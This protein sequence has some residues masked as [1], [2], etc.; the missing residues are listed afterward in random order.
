VTPDSIFWLMDSLRAGQSQVIE[1]QARLSVS[2]PFVPFPLVSASRVSAIN[3]TL[4]TNNSAGVTVYGIDRAA[5]P[6]KPIPTLVAEP[7]IVQVGE[8]IQLKAQVTASVSAWDLWVYYVNGEVDTTFAD[9][10][11]AAT[12]L[13]PNTWQ[14]IVPQFTN[15]R[16]LTAARI[17]PIKFELRIRDLFG[18]PDQAEAIVSVQSSNA[19]SLDRNTFEPGYGEPI[20][21]Q[22]KL[23]SNRLACLDLYDVTGHHVSKLCE[24]MYSAGWNNYHWDGR[25]S[26]GQPVGSGVYIITI[27]SGEYHDWKK[28]I[29]VR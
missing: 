16:L 28:F 14:V 3:D 24:S 18:R 4:L 25:T 13:Q 9:D 29:L 1:Y 2:L 10:F 22:F 26:N 20:D 19:L 12:V 23:S 8:P 5:T 6:I 11:I 7:L 17:E 21:I 15:T 27:R